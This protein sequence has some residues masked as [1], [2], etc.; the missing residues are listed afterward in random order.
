MAKKKQAAG[1]K[2]PTKAKKAP[3]KTMKKTPEP[4]KTTTRSKKTFSVA[5]FSE[6]T[7]LTQKG[8]NEWVKQGKLKGEKDENGNW[9]VDA[10]S[11]QLP[12]MKR[13]IR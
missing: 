3:A 10:A 4:K 7:Y 12:F 11:L 13:L 8:V 9:L 2:A 5:E 1:K 6:K